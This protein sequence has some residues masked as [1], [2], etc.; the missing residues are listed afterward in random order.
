MAGGEPAATKSCGGA[1]SGVGK[2]L[3]RRR[4]CAASGLDSLGG[5]GEG[6]A[7]NSPVAFDWGGDASH[8]GVE[9]GH[10]SGGAAELRGRKRE[11]GVV[12]ARG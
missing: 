6:N 3:G 1:S 4:R 12:R 2:G 11:N 5:V 10:G 7:A 8:T 9:L